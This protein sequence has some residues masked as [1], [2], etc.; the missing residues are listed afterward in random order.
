M[1]CSWRLARALSCSW[2]PMLLPP[3]GVPAARG[4]SRSKG[5]LTM[6][7]RVRCGSCSFPVPEPVH[8]LASPCFIGACILMPCANGEDS[9]R[10]LESEPDDDGAL[11]D[12][13]GGG[14]RVLL[15]LAL[16]NYP[17]TTTQDFDSRTETSALHEARNP[18][19]RAP[20]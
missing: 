8:A 1:W 19:L 18:R 4:D 13:S 15:V 20:Q 12:E 10:C 9:R 5:A 16:R 7:L 14:L 3:N 11:L 2:A 17:G 6:R